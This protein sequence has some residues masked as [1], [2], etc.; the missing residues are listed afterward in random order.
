MQI[1]AGPESAHV[2]AFSVPRRRHQFSVLP[3]GVCNCAG[4]FNGASTM[5]ITATVAPNLTDD[6]LVYPSDM[7]EMFLRLRIAVD[8]LEHADVMPGHRS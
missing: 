4:A 6:L 3:F 2:T 7:S 8:W 1:D 5:P